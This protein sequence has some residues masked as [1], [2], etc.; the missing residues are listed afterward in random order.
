MLLMHEAGSLKIGEVIRYTI[1]YVPSQDP[2]VH[3]SSA[4]Y[5]RIKNGCTA[6][7]RAAFMRGPYNLSVSAYPA[8]YN[9][10]E[11]FKDAD[12]LG[13]PTFEPYLRAGGTW[14][15][16][17]WI[18]ER[19]RKTTGCRK[20][21]LTIKNRDGNEV[22]QVS[23]I[24]EISSQVVFS[25]SA[26]VH[27]EVLLGS[28]QSCLSPDASV[29]H[30]NPSARRHSLQGRIRPTRSRT[31]S[32]KLDT[33]KKGVFSKA[34][35]LKVEDTAVL[36][37][38]PCLPENFRDDEYLREAT[39]SESDSMNSKPKEGR[40]KMQGKERLKKFH[41]VVLTHGLHSN[42]GADMLY[43]KESIDATVKQAKA[44]A[45]DCRRERKERN[46]RNKINEI[47]KVTLQLPE[48]QLYESEEEEEEDVVVRGFSGNVARTERGIKY[49]GK[50]L[51]R[52]VLSMTHPEQPFRKVP[53]RRL[54]QA[55]P[56]KRS[57]S[58][59]A[60]EAYTNK[61][62]EK[63]R[64]AYKFT[65]ISFIGH[66]LGGI[67][68]T[69]AVAY[70]QKHW[71]NFF[72]HIQPINFIALATP[73]LGLSNENP[74]YVKFAL[75]FGFI[76]RTG[77]DLG[78]AWSAPTIA[79]SGL[80]AIFGLL[81]ENS[82]SNPDQYQPEDKP[83]LQILPM[84]PAHT[85]LKRFKNRTVYSN[86]VNDGIVPLRTSCLFF[87]DWQ[88]L[89]KVEKAKRES[90]LIGKF[91]EWSWAEITGAT[92]SKLSQSLS[93]S[94]INSSNGD[95]EKI[96][97][98]PSPLTK[99]T[100]DDHIEVPESSTL[101]TFIK[102]IHTP[103]SP[104]NDSLCPSELRQTKI[105]QRSQTIKSPHYASTFNPPSHLSSEIL[106]TLTD[107]DSQP[108][109]T[110]PRTSVFE[111]AGD[112]L[113]PP[114]PSVEYLLNISSRPQSIFHDRIYHPCDI[115]PP[116]QERKVHRTLSFQ[117]FSSSTDNI[118][119][120]RSPKL[121]PRMDSEKNKFEA[122]G[123]VYSGGMKIEERI[124]R[125]YHRDLSWRK[126]L[127][128]LEP[129]AHNNIIV[130]R[131]F[132]NANGW[133]VVKHLCDAHFSE[134]AIYNSHHDKT[135]P[136]VEE[137]SRNETENFVYENKLGCY[138]DNFYNDS[139][140]ESEDDNQS[141]PKFQAEPRIWL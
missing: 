40:G 21:S 72:D 96:S 83:L 95:H 111:S 22:E 15:C 44:N 46:K 13:I 107:S 86:V 127:V 4:L 34:I 24:V 45:E 68:Q 87:I 130:R 90:G 75:D 88:C 25:G 93:I 110:P 138:E 8:T 119:G 126:V 78:L 70:I 28:D 42:I 81:S 89:G 94:T 84:G 23:W 109:F 121:T 74:S 141:K 116:V 80:G 125:A 31:N 33:Q 43:L 92:S 124:A 118:S 49:L 1:T 101:S 29:M 71:P 54:S 108:M 136:L 104:I 135:W 60:A 27:F 98:C 47:S 73:F 51:A 11:E 32:N 100:H 79:R 55:I 139:D 26:L 113:I 112:L 69:Y 99:L 66:S 2:L 48:D 106:V 140:T 137:I 76:G 82:P 58:T 115:P 39:G 36:W 16:K 85:A 12:S 67:V 18:P 35:E 53:K 117:P 128:R 123:H 57:E 77:Q 41:L 62:R 17:L 38:K 132:A 3:S 52:Y 5:L 65:S 63:K 37:S 129:D 20:E 14:D 103:K 61:Y 102:R 105:Y 9:P 91:A 56:H 97:K 131:M 133:P 30:R 64:R 114:L 7:L 10:N 122:S 19:L 6:A 134:S 59:R 50:R 120:S